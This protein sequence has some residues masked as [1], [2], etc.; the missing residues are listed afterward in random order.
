MWCTH[1]S[2]EWW[3]AVRGG[4]FGEAWWKENLRMTKF[5][6]DHLCSELHPYITRLT[7]V[8]E[9]VHVEERVTVT[10]WRLATNIEY[11]TLM[12]VFGL[13]RSTVCVVVLDTCRAIQKLLPCYVCIPTDERLH[14]IVDGFIACWGFPQAVGAIDGTHIPILRPTG[15]SGSDYFNRKEFYSI[16]M[17]AVVDYQGLFLYT[18][19][20]WLARKSS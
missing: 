2:K 20:C 13:G 10:L 14:N 8:R 15:D 18:Y 1:K 16:V 6:F 3:N 11:R 17:Q 5:T 12:V 9:P 4:L 19:V 7:A